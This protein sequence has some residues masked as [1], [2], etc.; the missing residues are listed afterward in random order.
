MTTEEKIQLWKKCASD[1]L[2]RE[3]QSLSPEELK[4]RFE[5]DLTFGTAGLRGKMGVGTNRLNV[6]TVRKYT[7]T[8]PRRTT[9]RALPYVMT[10]AS[11]P[12]RLPKKPQKS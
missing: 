8:L 11:T 5:S 7:L 12:K 4:E 10:H 1:D 3:M 6:Y 2:L 9:P